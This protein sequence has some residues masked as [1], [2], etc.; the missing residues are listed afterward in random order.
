MTPEQNMRAC[1]AAFAAQSLADDL[2]SAESLAKAACSLG[3]ASLQFAASGKTWKQSLQYVRDTGAVRWRDLLARQ[4]AES[5]FLLSD[6]L[7]I[8]SKQNLDT[9]GK[10][11]FAERL[12]RLADELAVTVGGLS[13]CEEE[14]LHRLDHPGVALATLEEEARRLHGV[15]PA[16]LSEIK[17]LATEIDLNA[18]DVAAEEAKLLELKRKVTEQETHMNQAL[19]EQQRAITELD[20]IEL[21]ISAAAK[22]AENTK[23]FIRTKKTELE[24]VANR[25][26]VIRKELEELEGDPRT[27]II[28]AINRAMRDLPRDNFDQSIKHY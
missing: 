5:A 1:A 18:S 11:E 26:E 12:R 23:N 19:E 4:C 22:A 28:E 20:R 21:E 27:E 8:L 24:N 7:N 10:K 16:V 9:E 13:R 15:P 25:A 6:C 17:R 2:S 14:L 3:S